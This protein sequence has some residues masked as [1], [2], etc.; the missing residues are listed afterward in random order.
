LHALGLSKFDT[1][2]M[3]PITY[4]WQ[5]DCDRERLPKY[6]GAVERLSRHPLPGADDLKI[7]VATER[8]LGR[9]TD[10]QY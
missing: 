2:D 1:A 6:L 3:I 9:Y 5:M 4:K 10:S 8:S 7:L